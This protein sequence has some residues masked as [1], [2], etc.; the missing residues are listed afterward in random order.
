MCAAREKRRAERIVDGGTPTW[1][2]IWSQLKAS[3]WTHKTPPASSNETWWKFI[4]PGRKAN[5]IN[6]KDYFLGEARVCAHYVSVG[7]SVEELQATSQDTTES[8]AAERSDSPPRLRASS[9]PVNDDRDGI[10][11]SEDENDEYELVP[12]DRVVLSSPA[13]ILLLGRLGLA[14]RTK[15]TV[16][17]KLSSTRAMLLSS[18]TITAIADYEDGAS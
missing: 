16:T 2:H 3:G 13:A 12:R 4:P 8:T 9:G 1:R 6:A 10:F 7:P 17:M 15:M 5:D 14:R 18:T 11:S